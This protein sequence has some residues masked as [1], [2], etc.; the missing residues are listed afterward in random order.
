MTKEKYFAKLLEMFSEHIETTSESKEAEIENKIMDFIGRNPVWPK[1]W[2]GK[3]MS[4]FNDDG[5]I[6]IHGRIDNS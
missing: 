3:K 4:I 1:E 2:R 6:L 5:S